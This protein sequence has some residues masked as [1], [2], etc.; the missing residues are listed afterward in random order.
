[1]GDGG[2]GADDATA[3]A[4]PEMKRSLKDKGKEGTRPASTQQGPRERDVVNCSMLSL[5]LVGQ[6]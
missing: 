3:S 6:D 1:V 4:V 5:Y 2:S